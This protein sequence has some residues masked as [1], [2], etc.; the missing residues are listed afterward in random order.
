MKQ[1]NDYPPNIEQIRAAF[2]LHKGIVFTYGDTIYNPDGGFIDQHLEAHEATHALQQA[3]IGVDRWW[4]RY[5]RDPV[6]RFRQELE[7][8]RAQ[9]QDRKTVEK[10]RNTLT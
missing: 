10:D 7:A 4:D 6:F 2:P 9:Y 5:I 8:Y 3:L 1:I